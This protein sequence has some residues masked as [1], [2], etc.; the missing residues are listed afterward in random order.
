[1]ENDTDKR[2]SEFV[3]SLQ[4]SS[5]VEDQLS[6]LLKGGNSSVLSNKSDFKRTFE[7]AQIACSTFKLVLGDDAI[8]K[9]GNIEEYVKASW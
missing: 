7:S 6:T 1:M 8:L 5:G 9:D 4:L 2:V 3:E